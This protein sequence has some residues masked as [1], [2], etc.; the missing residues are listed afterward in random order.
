MIPILMHQMHISTNQVEV[1]SQTTLYLLN[2]YLP[3]A[4]LFVATALC[5][6]VKSVLCTIKYILPSLSVLVLYIQA[7]ESDKV[8]PFTK[9]YL[10]T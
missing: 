4:I 7:M 9:I 1:W 3:T 6:L 10:Y 2:I 8:T 5:L